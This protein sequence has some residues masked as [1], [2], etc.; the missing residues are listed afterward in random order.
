[1]RLI[2][3]EVGSTSWLNAAEFH[4]T[5]IYCAMRH[6]RPGMFESQ[7]EAEILKFIKNGVRVSSALRQCQGAGANACILHYRENASR[8]DPVI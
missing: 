1:M 6:A 4:P 7:V 2:K 8:C 5:P 3:D